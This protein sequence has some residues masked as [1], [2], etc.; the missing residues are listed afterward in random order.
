M[1][2]SNKTDLN[3]TI[4]F[5]LKTKFGQDKKAE[6]D[7]N[8]IHAK[9]EMQM[10]KT[11]GSQQ[12]YGVWWDPS[13]NPQELADVNAKS[14]LIIFEQSWESGKVPADWNLVNIVLI[15]K[16]SKKEDH[17][18]C[19]PVSL[20]SAPGKVMEK[21]YSGRYG[22]QHLNDNTVIGHSQHSF[23]RG[24]SCLSNLIS[25][26]DE[27]THLA[28]HRKQFDVISMD[29]SKAFDTVSHRILLD[30]FPAQAG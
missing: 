7:I 12:I 22:N 10:K 26:Y 3:Y 8:D 29:F 1:Q 20:S 30:K 6:Y 28:D 27:G 18:N 25:F 4:M 13:Q 11:T 24:K 17:G 15:L 19:R 2:H 23:M 16:K 14:L 9:L 21:K 5:L